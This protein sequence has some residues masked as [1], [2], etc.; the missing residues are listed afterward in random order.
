MLNKKCKPCFITNNHL[1]YNKNLELCVDIIEKMENKCKNK[2]CS[3]Y[4]CKEK[5][6]QLPYCQSF[7]D[8]LK[9]QKAK[10]IYSNENHRAQEHQ[11]NSINYQPYMMLNKKKC[12]PYFVSNE[13]LIYNKNVELRVDNIEK[14]ENKCKNKPCSRY[15]CKENPRQL[16]YCQSF[17]DVLKMKKAQNVYSSDNHRA[18]NHPY[19]NL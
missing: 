19:N 6:R 14:I 8:V 4:A 15:A 7:E 17:E 3:R 13:Q 1:I 12:N 16:P 10:N 5:P 18:H 2:P 11:Y 9:M